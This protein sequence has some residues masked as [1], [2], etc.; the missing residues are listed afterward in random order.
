MRSAQD[1]AKK[2]EKLARKQIINVAQGVTAP[3]HEAILFPRH[4]EAVNA[5]PGSSTRVQRSADDSQ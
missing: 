2:K 5:G 1:R 4:A 3:I